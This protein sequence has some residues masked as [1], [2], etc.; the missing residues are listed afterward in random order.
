MKSTIGW[1]VGF[2]LASL[3]L[4]AAAFNPDSPAVV[5]LA[6][7]TMAKIATVEQGVLDRP[8]WKGVIDFAHAV[9]ALPRLHGIPQ[10]A[11]P[12]TLA[13][14]TITFLAMADPQ[15]LPAVRGSPAAGVAATRQRKR[16]VFP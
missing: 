16:R 7:S 10:A 5:S 3:G 12:T 2:T 1:L 6:P 14:A 8:E 4:P 9:D 11:G 13:P 15:N